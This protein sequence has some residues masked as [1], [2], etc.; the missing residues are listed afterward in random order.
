[1]LLAAGAVVLERWLADRQAA[2]SRVG[3]GVT[4]VLL[5]GAL[6]IGAA[7]CLPLAPVGSTLWIAASQVQDNFVE[8][9]GWPELVAT[10]AGVYAS[11][12]AETR[13]NTAILVANYGEAGALDL[14]GPA[15]GLPA[16]ISGVNSYGL[17]GAPQPAPQTVI[18]LGY[19]REEAESF[20]ATCDLAATITNQ[21]GVKNEESSRPDV[22][23][24]RDPRQPWPTLWSALRHFG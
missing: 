9:I 1:M 3:W 16:V 7:L 14:Y 20:F 15:Y 2:W 8:E 19:R 12:P 18:V 4:G 11:L 6:A 21:A 23:V 17:R 10:V 13:P 22:F 5:T 24:C